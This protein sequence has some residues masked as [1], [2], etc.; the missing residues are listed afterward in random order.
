MSELSIVDIDELLHEFWLRFAIMPHAIYVP[1]Y[2]PRHKHIP[3][4]KSKRMRLKVE[5]GCWFKLRRHH[6]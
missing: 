3:R 4:Q 2:L 1:Y 6:E 5:R